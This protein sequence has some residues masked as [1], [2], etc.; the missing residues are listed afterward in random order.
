MKARV[1]ANTRPE[2]LAYM[3]RNQPVRWSPRGDWI[4]FRDGDTLRIIS[5]EGKQNHM[6][7]QRVWETYGWSKDGT[8]VLG[9]WSTTIV[10]LC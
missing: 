4:V 9:I 2:L 1:G 5:P 8:A 3:A 10:I 7:S 6:I